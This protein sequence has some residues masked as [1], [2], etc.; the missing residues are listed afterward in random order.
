VLI[1]K[2]VL[3][4]S[5]LSVYP[6]KIIVSE[7]GQNGETCLPADDGQYSSSSIIFASPK[8]ATLQIPFSPMRTF[9]AA[10]SL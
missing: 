3:L 7:K 2:F 5:A 6:E 8:S 1:N 10:R 9:R 4:P